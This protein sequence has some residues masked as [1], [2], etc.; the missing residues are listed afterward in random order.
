[1]RQ[2]PLF[3]PASGRGLISLLHTPPPPCLSLSFSL[4]KSGAERV[5]NGEVA[6]GWNDILGCEGLDDSGI[7][8]EKT[9]ER[10]KW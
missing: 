8:R 4:S 10:E 1:M 2:L 6:V 9:G 5:A 7:K 3:P